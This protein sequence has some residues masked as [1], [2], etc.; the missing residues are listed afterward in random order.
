MFI[1]YKTGPTQL[2]KRKRKLQQS[3][4][5]TPQLDIKF[6]SDSQFITH[7]TLKICMATK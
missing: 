5:K 1:T 2:L 4:A 6:E 7:V 3:L